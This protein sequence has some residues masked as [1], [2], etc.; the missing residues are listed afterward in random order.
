MNRIF[1]AWN[2]ALQLEKVFTHSQ[3]TFSDYVAKLQNF[4]QI[5]ACPN[6]HIHICVCLCMDVYVFV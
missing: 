2:I 3:L 4:L 6:T 5:T 1:L